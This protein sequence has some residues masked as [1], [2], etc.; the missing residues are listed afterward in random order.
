[1]TG[2]QTTPRAEQR[3]EPPSLRA[4]LAPY[5]RPRVGRSIFEVATSLVPYLA[6]SALMYLLVDESVPLTLL[7]AV[8]TA[9]FLLRTYMVFHDCA[10]GSFLPSK[11]AN[12]WL[13]GLCGLLLFESFDRWR[14]S[15][16]VHHASAGD[17]DRRD[18]AGGALA[19]PGGFST[20]AP[21]Q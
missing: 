10:H 21:E 16:A 19:S 2:L 17:L 9:G 18:S 15:H 5:A 4:R 1:M 14:H 3:E 20:D 13:G 12:H 7:L 6:L 11:R 8:P